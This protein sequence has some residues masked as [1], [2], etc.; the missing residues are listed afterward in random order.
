MFSFLVVSG[1]GRS[2]RWNPHQGYHPNAPLSHMRI[3][4]ATHHSA[5]MALFQS[6]RRR[7]AASLGSLLLFLLGTTSV[8]AFLFPAAPR[9]CR[10]NPSPMT[11]ATTMRTTQLFSSAIDEAPAPAQQQ[12]QPVAQEQEQQQEQQQPARRR[13]S[14][15][16]P[17]GPWVL[18][19][20]R[21]EGRGRIKRREDCEG[22][23]I[24]GEI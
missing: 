6:S 2:T 3:R 5:I 23:G 18:L 4:M 19:E 9:A 20:G 13:P 14:S 24:G 16:K 11:I 15:P 8:S 1:V 22:R 7:A 17:S 12:E 10:S 21:Q